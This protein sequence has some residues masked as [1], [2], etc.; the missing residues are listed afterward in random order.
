MG[1]AEIISLGTGALGSGISRNWAKRDATD[2]AQANE[3]GAERA[4]DFSSAEALANRNFQERMSNTS[5]Q[6]GTADMMAAGLNPM[7]AFHQ[8]GASTPS[9]GQ[10]SGSAAQGAAT[11]HTDITPLQSLS[12]AAQIENVKAG[13]EKTRAEEAEIVAR[14]KTYPVTIE[15]MGQEIKESEQRI[16]QSV[17]Q[18]ENLKSGE[19]L[20]EQ[21]I[22]NLKETIAQIRATVKNL[23][24]HTTL[25][26]AQTHQAFI[27]SGA[28]A[29]QDEETRQRIRANLPLLKNMLDDLEIK[30]RH[31]QLPQ[32]GMDAAAHSSFLGALGAVG[33]ALN[34]FNNL[35]K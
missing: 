27:Q 13:T 14:T 6:R 25:A 12:T 26:G 17:Q 16:N 10:G 22:A 11:R 24:A 20:N 5:Y 30:F 31:L 33:R 35:F 32:R 19:R 2:Q 18:V 9:G 34:P 3:R 1:M 15:R 29:A 21:H 7:L 8:G 28:T 23:T 4:M